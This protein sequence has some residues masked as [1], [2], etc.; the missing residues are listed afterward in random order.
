MALNSA[1]QYK[2][3]AAVRYPRGSGIGKSITA[4]EDLIEIGKS[5]KI[6]D[7]KKCCILNFGV[8]LS[9][10]EKLAES[11]GFGLYDMRFVK[12]IDE[13]ALRE[14]SRNYEYIVTLEDHTTV[15]GAGSAVGE[16]LHSII[17]EANLLS[18]GLQD[19]FPVHG[20][21]NEILAINDLDE[22]GIEKSIKNF[23]S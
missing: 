16:F 12:P 8:L 7:G 15:G 17:S 20:S 19:E 23:L 22:T 10:V 11:N 21:R 4:S 14:I 9:R 1:Y 6:Y 3:P 18:L 13:E 2:G 5:K